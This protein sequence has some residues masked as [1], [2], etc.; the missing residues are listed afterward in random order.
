VDF[1][2]ATAED[3]PDLFRV[4]TSVWENHQ[5]EEE[6]AALGVTRGS[7]SQ[8]LGSGQARA[9]CAIENGAIVG[10]S[11][12]RRSGRDV[13]ALFVLPEFEGRGIGASL[14]KLA[15]AWLRQQSGQPIRLTTER[16]TRAYSLYLLWGWREVGELDDGDPILEI[17]V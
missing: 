12:A 11:M 8:M 10:F 9:W 7:V 16:C 15:V 13:F 1:R 14:L 17:R 5:S 2:I 6:L 3:V 4:R